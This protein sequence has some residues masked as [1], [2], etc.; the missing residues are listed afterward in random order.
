ML[1]TVQKSP[2]PSLYVGVGLRN[3]NCIFANSAVWVA[4]VLDYEV[5]YHDLH[6]P[7]PARLL[8]L[9]NPCIYLL[10]FLLEEERSSLSILVEGEV[11]GDPS[12]PARL[13]ELLDSVLQL[14]GSH[15][16]G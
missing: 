15:G 12:G 1:P 16:H 14:Y 3:R 11:A 5:P 8:V 2:T 4:R 10:N 6:C 7:G 13:L 9:M